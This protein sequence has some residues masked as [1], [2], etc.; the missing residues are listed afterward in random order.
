MRD[1]G[2]WE[3][4]GTR[5]RTRTWNPT[6]IP[7]LPNMN[8]IPSANLPFLDVEQ[9]ERRQGQETFTK[10]KKGWGSHLSK[11]PCTGCSWRYSGL[12]RS[13]LHST[14]S[15]DH[16]GIPTQICNSRDRTTCRGVGC[17][18]TESR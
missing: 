12:I 10:E 15:R 17:L 14:D 6:D 1:A 18:E 2:I 3:L 11:L 13:H 7:L 9:H 5:D 8:E 16:I 4:W